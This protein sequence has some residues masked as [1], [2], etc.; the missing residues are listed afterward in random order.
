M[1]RKTAST[2]AK[3]LSEA[4][5]RLMQVISEAAL[6]SEYDLSTA[7]SSVARDI[8]KITGMLPDAKPV[9]ALPVNNES[10]T[11][12]T[13]THYDDSKRS[14]PKHQKADYPRFKIQ[15]S[16]LI[17][18]GWSKK[19]K[20]EYLHKVSYNIFPRV[21]RAMRDVAG[22]LDSPVTAEDIIEHLEN[23]SDESTPSYQVYIVLGFLKQ[24]ECIE[25]V[26]REGYRIP[27]PIEEIASEA[28]NAVSN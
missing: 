22:E 10:I 17:R 18:I 3:L 15:N 11:K 16:V 19:F 24:K 27:R 2:V 6:A 25:Q 9:D 21:T 8:Q 7:A 23:S 1:N 4:E 13:Q 5:A 28:W 26:G 14:K 12:P 20:R